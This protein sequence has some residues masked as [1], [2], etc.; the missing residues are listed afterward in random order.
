MDMELLA[1]IK[2]ELNPIRQDI[3][4]LK[5]ELAPIKQDITELRSELTPIRQDIGRLENELAPIRQDINRL[6]DELTPIK[7]N[8]SRL[9]NELVPIKQDI[10]RIKI[11]MEHDIPR[12]FALLAEGQAII[13]DC[14]LKP[15]EF[16]ELRDRVDVLE[17]VVT[18]HSAEIAALQQA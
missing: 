17:T 16:N 9:E 3:A 8:I 5:S 15:G 6:K 4:E 12:Q 11:L 1:A 13:M 2:D 18:E 14:L 10:N 7:H